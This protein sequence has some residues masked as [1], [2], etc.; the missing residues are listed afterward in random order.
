MKSMKKLIVFL[1]A[2]TL[3]L[4]PAFAIRGGIF[5]SNNSPLTVNRTLT[6][7]GTASLPS[8]SFSGDTNT[9]WYSSGADE[10]SLA[11]GGGQWLRFVQGQVRLLSNDLTF[12]S[13][14]DL[15][16]SRDAANTLGQRNSTNAQ[17]FRVY[18]TYTDASNYELGQLS[19]Q[20]NQFLI[21]STAAGTG[22]A[23]TLVLGNGTRTVVGSTT[24][25]AATTFQVNGGAKITSN[26]STGGNLT[27]TGGTPTLSTA[28]N[29]IFTST[30]NN[31]ILRSPNAI[32]LNDLSS[33]GAN[34]TGMLSVLGDKI[35]IS[36][37]KT[38]TSSTEACTTGT[39][40][41]DTNYTYVCVATNT[42]K[43]SALAAF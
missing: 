18:N 22:T 36:T 27:F 12:G 16:L 15:L 40:V 11:L 20:T 4:S 35:R 3:A 34:I 6:G 7:S 33:A 29:F 31:V 5:I 30:A 8:Y 42:W 41:W 43:R 21:G 37:A 9:G 24:D 10:I 13:G 1:L 32:A 23:R 28:D 25:D 26:I 38:P 39:V 19:W 2:Y 14:S 17:A